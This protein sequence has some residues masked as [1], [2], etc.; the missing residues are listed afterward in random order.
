MEG[1]KLLVALLILLAA[2]PTF[3]KKQKK[4]KYALKAAGGEVIASGK[5]QENEIP[6][7]ESAKSAA[8]KKAKAAK[9]KPGKKAG[10]KNAAS[11]GSEENSNSDAQEEEASR[12]TFSAIED[13]APGQSYYITKD[14]KNKIH[15]VQKLS[16]NEIPDIKNYRIIIEKAADDGTWTQVL[17][18][19][20]LENK[21][22]VSFEAGRYR[23][24]VS[25]I[26]LFDQLEKSSSWRE[27]EVL[28]A[29]QPKIG[30]METN[31]I[32]LNS[33]KADG[34]FT[35]DGENLTESTVFTM[36]QKGAEPPKILYG[37]ILSVDPEGKSAQVQFDI[38]QMQEGR[39]EIYAQNPGGLSVIS[40]SINLKYKKE[41]HWRFMASAG[42]T[43]PLTFFDGT[44]DK[45]TEHNF[46][47]IS[48]TAS[49]KLI[50]FHT[51]AGDIGF[52]ARGNFSLFSNDTDKYE[53]SGKYANIF[54]FLLWQ[55]YLIPE[56]LCLELHAGAGIAKMFD[57]KF[58]NKRVGAE[59]PK[60]D[61]LALAFGAG[62]GLQYFIGKRF[63]IEG[64]VDFILAKFGG[65]NLGM[66]YP[67]L[68]IGGKF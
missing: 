32:Y 51:K 1:K 30:S 10:K 17:E 39:Y 37:K 13:P 23:F 2:V 63:F 47:P 55:K 3:A 9:K 16:W 59:S 36:E 29:T 53:M 19:D 35:L 12:Y 45:Y 18:K 27:F 48:G 8:E 66:L 31:S 25:V 28:K 26:N 56:R 21:I 58:K 7:A 20:L 4:H 46:Y 11:L 44:F 49:L 60:F 50:S 6:G 61:S 15:F 52:G 41:R 5:F 40:R 54:G 42:Y 24:Q 22:E 64:N 65:M 57:T 62:L 43:F 34:T 14:E 38:S 67:S 33:K 68:G